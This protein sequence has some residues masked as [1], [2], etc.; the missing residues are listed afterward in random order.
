MYDLHLHSYHSFDATPSAED[1][2]AAADRDGVGCLA[3]TDHYVTDVVPHALNVT[4]QYP[5]IRYIPAVELGVVTSFGELD[6]LCYGI[7][8]LS[9]LERVRQTYIEWMHASAVAT[10]R[11]MQLIGYDYT[12]EI[13]A[14]LLASYRP[15]D[16]LQAQGQ[17]PLRGTV[18]RE[19]FMSQG[20]TTEREGFR[21]ILQRAENACPQPPYPSAETILP[22]VRESGALVVLAHPPMEFGEDESRL[23]RLHE[24]VALDGI[25]CAHP[26]VPAELSQ[27]CRSY[28]LDHGLVSTAGTDSHTIESTAPQLG[29]HGGAEEWL[30][31]FLE[32]LP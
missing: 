24:E 12:D 7:P 13:H 4:K 32:R 28:C 27:F 3:I 18:H 19:Y 16:V 2:F 31:E 14:E 25:E 5:D 10:I 23:A 22:L 9:S 30:A 17:A 20:Y 29:R 1:I 11:G 26:R 21:D 8:N 6:L 15:A